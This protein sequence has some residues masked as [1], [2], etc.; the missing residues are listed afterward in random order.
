MTNLVQAIAAY[1]IALD[2]LPQSPADDAEARVMN[3]LTARDDLA[4]FLNS[5]PA[6]D[7][8]SA[9]LIRSLDR[10]LKDNV[11]VIDTIVGRDTLAEWRESIQPPSTAWWWMLDQIAADIEPKPN[12]FW[13]ILTGFFVT[14]SFALVAEIGQRFLSAGVDTL[15]VFSTL[16]Q[17]LLVVLAGSAFTKTGSQEIERTLLRLHVK[18]TRFHVW[19][20]GL[21][22]VI[23]LIIISVRLLIP[24][25]A[26]YYN[27]LAETNWKAGESN[28]AVENYLRAISLSSNFAE[29]HFNL[30][31]AYERLLQFEPA[32]SAFQNA[33]RADKQLFKAYIRLSRLQIANLND[34]PGAL[35][36][37][38]DALALSS[39]E[40]TD[41]YE[42]TKNRGW[43]QLNL[44]NYSQSQADLQTAMQL[45]PEGPAAHCLM[46]QLLET[47]ANPAQDTTAAL[48]EWQQCLTLSQGST[49]PLEDA[50]L[51]TAQ[52]RVTQGY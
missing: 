5:T 33:I 18:P 16:I 43:A 6:I 22:F 47:P 25:F 4:R 13:A 17:G 3:T 50:W 15:A 11:L 51:A 28:L 2:N 29:A 19:K 48:A 41:Q 46:A 36:L 37:L 44:T 10:Q 42:L 34:N 21:A 30:G 7:A 9:N 23:L 24:V 14:M 45:R 31:N 8:A 52:E 38:N 12:L 27:Q 49:D 20:T 32:A 39:T 1:Q 35:T 26:N 40:P